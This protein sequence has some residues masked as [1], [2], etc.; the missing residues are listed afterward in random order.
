MICG[1][2]QNPILYKTQVFSAFFPKDFCIQPILAIRRGG[3]RRVLKLNQYFGDRF[4]A[5]S[6]FRGT[7]WPN[8]GTHWMSPYTNNTNFLF[9]NLVRV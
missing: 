1:I 6:T 5:K 2:W 7:F 8:K 3:G 4:G 9:K